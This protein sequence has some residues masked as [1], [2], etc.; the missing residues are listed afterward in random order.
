MLFVTDV[1]DELILSDMILEV[2]V[3]P[4]EVVKLSVVDVTVNE[5]VIDD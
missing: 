3:E 1:V 2:L 5:P 4:K